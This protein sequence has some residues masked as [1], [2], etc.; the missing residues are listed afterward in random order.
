MSVCLNLYEQVYL[1][2]MELIDPA[3]E[4]FI[5]TVLNS[6][7]NTDWFKIYELFYNN[8]NCYKFIIFTI[9]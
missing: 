1:G 9:S 4:I 5:E 8:Y 7:G 2:E 3:R 6:Y